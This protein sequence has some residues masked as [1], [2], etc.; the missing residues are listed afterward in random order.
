MLFRR[1]SDLE[2]VFFREL[3]ETGKT[4]YDEFWDHE[5]AMRAIAEREAFIEGYRMGVRMILAS[6]SDRDSSFFST[7]P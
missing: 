3:T 1:S 2:A 5:C 6:I 4:A 7:I